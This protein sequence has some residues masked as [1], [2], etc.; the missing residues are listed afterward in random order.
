M[1]RSVSARL[2]DHASIGNALTLQY[3]TAIDSVTFN[4]HLTY[5]SPYA[6]MT[7]SMGRAGDIDLA[8]TSGNARP[9]LEGSGTDDRLQQEIGTLALFPLISLRAGQ[10]AVQRG[11]D[12]EMGYSR[13][14]GSR[15]FSARMYHES[16]RNLALTVASPDGFLPVGDILPDFSS[17]TAVFNAGNFASMG[18]VASATQDLGDHVSATVIYGSTGALKADGNETVS[19]NPDE[20]R[21]MIH[22]GRQQ[23]V[24]MRVSAS[25][26]H[27]GTRIVASYQVAD[28]R[29]T[30]PD[31]SYS[32]ASLRP[33]PGF[34]VY[35]RQ[36]IPVLTGLPW[37]MELTADLRN[38]L[39]QGYLPL[40]TSDGSRLTLMETPRMFRGGLSFIF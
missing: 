13:T 18:Y 20:L 10:S 30:V 23:S 27:T 4:D 14:M 40:P 17:G 2:D 25:S 31:P 22:A 6:R 3:G 5:L 9:D 1:L 36:A 33:Q 32:T 7:Y 15:K 38:L 16:I 35:V 26:P 11:Q 8:Y 37:R 12:M 19:G 21:A 39:Q 28:S 24:T 29:W 34:N